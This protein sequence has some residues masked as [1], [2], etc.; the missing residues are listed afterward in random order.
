MFILLAGFYVYPTLFNLTNS[1]TDLSLFGLRRGGDWIGLEN[2]I[3]LWRSDGFRRVVFNTI[4]W[5]TLVG[6][7]VRIVLGLALAFLLSSRT[8]RRWRLATLSRVLLIVPWATPPVV[9][10]IVWR[11]LLDPRV[12]A[13]NGALMSLGV[14]DRPIAFLA[15]AAWVW[16][17]V[18][19]IITWNT[20]P[21]VSLTFLAS[22]QSLPQELLE[23]AEI[24]SANWLQKV[25]HIY[26]PHLKPAIVVM[27]LMSTFWTFN[28]F[29]Y[30]WLATGA[31]PGTLTNVMATEVYIKGFIDGRLGFSSAVGVVMATAMTICGLIYL[32]VV[33]ERELREEEER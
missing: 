31:G 11:W 5:L 1:F 19:T 9:A 28:N 15:E 22:L 10:I 30:V 33:A 7:G 20:L 25:R 2:Y 14:V 32:R 13:I 29:I 6:V 16:P 24:D 12:G 27:V 18:L 8:L 23:A 26:L 3:E 4:V 17:A 21:L